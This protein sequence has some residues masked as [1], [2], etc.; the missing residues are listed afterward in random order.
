MWERGQGWSIRVLV[1]G[2]TDGGSTCF[3]STRPASFDVF[4]LFLSFSIWY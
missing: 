3:E 4:Y 2:L 1:A